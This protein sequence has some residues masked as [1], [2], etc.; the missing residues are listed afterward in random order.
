MNIPAP[1]TVTLAD[2]PLTFTKLDILLV[3]DSTRKTAIA[4]IRP[5]PKPLVLWEHEAYDAAGDY[6]QAQVEARIAELLGADMAAS[7]SALI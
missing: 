2:L 5:L 7:L 4:F 3:D 6:T 1:V